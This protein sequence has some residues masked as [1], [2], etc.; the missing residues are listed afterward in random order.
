MQLKLAKRKTFTTTDKK[1]EKNASI[2]ALFV[3]IISNLK[4]NQN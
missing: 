4:L 3:V 1:R 2:E